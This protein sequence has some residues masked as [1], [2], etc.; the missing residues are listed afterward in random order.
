LLNRAVAGFE[1]IRATVGLAYAKKA[2]GETL[3]LAGSTEAEEWFTDSLNSF[4]LMRD[5]RGAA[6]SKNHIP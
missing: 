3:V 6:Y 1:D 4:E 2:V 5:E